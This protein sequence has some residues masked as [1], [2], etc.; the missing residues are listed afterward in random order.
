MLQCFLAV[1]LPQT[2]QPNEE[3]ML[4]ADVLVNHVKEETYWSHSQTLYKSTTACV[5][6]GSLLF[7]SQSVTSN[8]TDPFW[9][10]RERVVLIPGET[11]KKNSIL[12]HLNDSSSASEGRKDVCC[13]NSVLCSLTHSSA[14]M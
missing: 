10:K 1:Y 14:H 11:Q 6:Q 7:N 8:Q 9:E 5:F 4:M 2:V 3:H 13:L 12:I